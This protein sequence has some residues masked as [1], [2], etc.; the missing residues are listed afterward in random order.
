MKKSLTV[1]IFILLAA[2]VLLMGIMEKALSSLGGTPAVA[3]AYVI[4]G[5]FLLILYIKARKAATEEKSK[6]E[7][8]KNT[9]VH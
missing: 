9:D 8:K 6:N 3:A 2:A 5:I 7:D 4:I 1:A